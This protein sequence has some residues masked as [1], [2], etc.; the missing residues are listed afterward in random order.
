MAAKT[1]LDQREAFLGT[2]GLSGDPLF[3]NRKARFQKHS[4]QGFKQIPGMFL[5]PWLFFEA[6]PFDTPNLRIWPAASFLKL[7]AGGKPRTMFCRQKI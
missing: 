7:D 2:P 3:G 6:T 1:S 5:M 4:R